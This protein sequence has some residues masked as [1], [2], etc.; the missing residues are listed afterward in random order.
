MTTLEGVPTNN[1]SILTEEAIEKTK[2]RL[3]HQGVELNASDTDWQRLRSILR[4]YEEYVVYWTG[5]PNKGQIK[6]LNEVSKKANKLAEA[7]SSLLEE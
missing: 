6:R 2:D 4:R 3:L 1:A 7:I 5:F